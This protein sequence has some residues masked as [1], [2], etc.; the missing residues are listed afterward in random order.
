MCGIA[1]LIAPSETVVREAL[2]RMD[3]ALVHRGP[4]D[5]GQS[6]LPFG[7]R[8]LGFE[9]RRLSIIDL[10]PLGHQP[11]THPQSGDQI[12]FNGEIYNFQVLRKELESLGETF[13]GHSDTEVMLHAISRWGPDAIRRFEGMFA[14]AYYNAREQS[15]LL[16]RDSVGIKPLYVATIEGGIGF[17]SE[18]RAILAT[19]LVESKLSR[20]GL[21]SMLAYGSVQ[22]PLTIVEGIHS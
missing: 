10:S 3:C 9:H 12:T 20:A 8:F 21:A 16:A 22:Q 17:A 18:V 4:D 19:K 11:M 14:F 2:H 5:S 7:D 1:G 13:R 6:I 15:V